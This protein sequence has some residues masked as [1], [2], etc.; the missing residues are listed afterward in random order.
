MKA[1]KAIFSNLIYKGTGK[2]VTSGGIAVTGDRIIAVGSREEIETYIGED[3]EVFAYE[4]KLVL[5]GL[6]DSHIHITMGAMMDDNDI[7]LEGTKS[8]EECAGIVREYLER[9][10]K[11]TKR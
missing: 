4:D 3:T 9:K 8:G 1:D 10:S 6:I 5:P 7:N 2:E 11:R